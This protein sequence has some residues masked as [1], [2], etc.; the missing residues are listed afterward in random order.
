MCHQ[1]DGESNIQAGKQEV[2]E[3]MGFE[4]ELKELFFLYLQGTLLT[5][6]LRSIG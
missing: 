4:T 5:M 6:V 3:E 2:N 1:R